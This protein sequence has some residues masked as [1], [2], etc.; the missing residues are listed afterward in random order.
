[1]AFVN[2]SLLLG[3]LFVALPI[4]IHLALRRRPIP[5]KFPALMFLAERLDANRRQL[6]LRHWIL[7]LLRSAVVAVLAL[8]LARPSVAAAQFGPWLF[9]GGVFPLLVVTG[10]LLTL[11][12]IQKRSSLIIA[13]LGVTSAVLAALAIGLVGTR[14]A[15][16]AALLGGN[17]RAP[18]AAAIVI[19]TSPRMDYR[20]DNQSRLDA[21]IE[22]ATWLIGQLPAGSQ[23]AVVETRPE[24]P[25]FAVDLPAARKFVE[26]IRSSA[27]VEPLPTSISR[28]ISLLQ[29]SDLQRK[30]VYV[31]T[32]LTE[33]AWPAPLAADLRELVAEAGDISPYI[34][35]VGVE[36]PTNAFLGDLKLSADSLPF[37]STLYIEAQVGC[38]GAGLTQT[39]DL[40]LEEPTTERP[41]I[42]DG[43]TLLPPATRRDVATVSL[44]ENGIQTVEFQLK[45]L[46][47]R[48]HHGSVGL[49]TGDGLAID[50]IRHFTVQVRDASRVLVVAPTNV[51]DE[52][53]VEAIAP[54]DFRRQ[55]EARFDCSV[56]PPSE[57]SRK[58]LATYKVACLLDP[59]ALDGQA[60]REL[61]SYAAEGGNLA[62]FLGHNAH[63]P[64]KFNG[65]IVEELIGAALVRRWRAGEEGL[66]LAPTTFDHPVLLP[67]RD[68]SNST[69]WRESPVYRHWVVGELRPECSVLIRYSNAEPALLENR[70]ERGRVMTL[71]TPI[72]D[73]L[74]PVG[75]RSWN[76]LPTSENAW[77]YLVLINSLLDYLI[78]H[79]GVSLNYTVG[80]VVSLPNAA[81]DPSRYRLFPPTDQP[82]DVSSDGEEVTVRFTETPGAYRLKGQSA[83]PQVRGFAVNLQAEATD[84]SRSSPEVLAEF[85]GENQY[86]YTRE[87]DQIRFE[88]GQGRIGRE[89]YPYLLVF[90]VIVVGL[91]QLFA[92]RF[93]RDSK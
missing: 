57:L 50:D 34:V 3:S 41:V 7:L 56:I 51:F 55:G 89:F 76:E 46:P 1:M 31:L 66:V 8:A 19:D 45:G 86:R 82:V 61:S 83:A 63:P 10:T 70:Y 72:S 85:F 20:Y 18:V 65:P 5:Q 59:P 69:P 28:A 9:A 13:S 39:V 74:S 78:E 27:L 23:V 37:G 91:E 67:F 71:T 62:I 88:V 84:L 81:E 40:L 4:V 11:S 33:T 22:M 80:D 2:G 43:Q 58:D 29:Q 32:D 36:N 25:R 6:Q 79:Q 16:G 68:Q 26:R 49:R 87:R 42:V 21:G 77:P 30:E 53:L 48:V 64:E 15:G 92:N 17:E 73:P 75:R 47:T 38:V 14:P 90:L 35:D 60:W 44:Q 12:I 54:E 93:Y 52:L 24:T